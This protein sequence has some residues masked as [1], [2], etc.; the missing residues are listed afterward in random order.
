ME[1]LHRYHYFLAILIIILDT[2]HQSGATFDKQSCNKYAKGD[3]VIEEI[4][5]YAQDFSVDKQITIIQGEELSFQNIMHEKLWFSDIF[6]QA[7]VYRETFAGS[8]FIYIDE[9]SNGCLYR[10]DG[11]ACIESSESCKEVAEKLEFV[12]EEDGLVDIG[13]GANSLHWPMK[14]LKK[15]VYIGESSVRSI[16]TNLYVTCT[17]VEDKEETWVSEWQ[18]LNTA[19]YSKKDKFM[20]VLL[21]SQHK[22]FKGKKMLMDGRIDYTNFRILSNSDIPNGLQIGENQCNATKGNFLS[23]KPPVPSFRHSYTSEVDTTDTVTLESYAR[24]TSYHEYN[25]NAKLLLSLHTYAVDDENEKEMVLEVYD[26]STMHS[27]RYSLTNGSCQVAFKFLYQSS[28]NL[29]SPQEYWF[30]DSPKS[31]YLGIYMNRNIPC[32]TWLF[33][34]PNGALGFEAGDTV[35]L[36]LATY[37]WLKRHGMAN[38][39]FFPVQMIVKKQDKATF[40]SYYEFKND[41]SNRIP[42]LSLCYDHEDAVIGMVTLEK[43]NY[44]TKIVPQQIRFHDEF[45]AFIQNVTGIVSSMRISD[46]VTRPSDTIRDET[47]VIFRINGRFAGVKSSSHEDAYRTDPVTSKEAADKINKRV[48]I[49]KVTFSLNSQPRIFYLKKGSFAILENSDHF[50]Y[51]D[52]S[53]GKSGGY[54]KSVMAAVGITLLFVG[55]IISVGGIL[56]YKRVTEGKSILASFGMETLQD[57]K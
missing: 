31:T 12:T 18:V 20:P 24:H 46:V 40:S 33:E 19:K 50:E 29:P 34:Y 16:S 56:A 28:P 23:P 5:F 42:S 22:K 43:T 48:D 49:G 51:M 32:D 26:Y 1:H 35:T 15:Q 41:P 27:L 54:S 2:L 21:T 8:T 45:V 37:Q 38:N 53:S 25:Y 11:G 13:S 57:E 17:Y 7:M 4:P 3:N 10:E 47:D 30:L 9:L 6:K 44:Y 39:R 14:N 36:Y 52:N 55:L